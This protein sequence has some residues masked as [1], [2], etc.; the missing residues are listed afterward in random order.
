MNATSIPKDPAQPDAITYQPR[1]L[2]IVKQYNRDSYVAEFGEQPPSADPAFPAKYWFDTSKA[3]EGEGAVY[4]SRINPSTGTREL[5]SIPKAIARRVNIP[6]AK[7][8]P[9]YVPAPTPAVVLF[10]GVINRGVDP[11]ELST[12]EQA[13]AMV[14]ETGAIEYLDFTPV[15]G[16]L[17]VDLRGETRRMLVLRYADNRPYP[18]VGQLMVEKNRYGI[19][20]PVQVVK[21]G[22][23]APDWTPTDTNETVAKGEPYWVPQRALLPNEKVVV[24]N[25]VVQ[26]M[27]T[28]KDTASAAGGGLT[29]EE[30][31]MLV[32]IHQNTKKV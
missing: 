20:A 12:E 29:A 10:N 23:T 13:K 28:D 21:D 3:T 30:H 8:Y 5:I 4:Y 7:T 26:V 16:A 17:A 2:E 19:G 9:A 31:T 14:V 32:E 15:F 11:A 22:P 27:R 25:F 18:Y 6:G 24:A 1:D